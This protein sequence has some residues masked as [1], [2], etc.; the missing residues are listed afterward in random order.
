MKTKISVCLFDMGGV[1]ARH[2]DSQLEREIL[3]KLGI[4]GYKHFFDLDDRLEAVMLEHTKGNI[5]EEELWLRFSEIT[6]IAVD[7]KLGSLW[8]TY[9]HPQLDEAVLS[10]IRQLKD[11]GMRVVCATN[12]EIAHYSFHKKRG[13]YSLFDKVYASVD[14][15]EA[16]PDRK[17]FEKILESEN[18]APSQAFF[19]DDSQSNCDSAAS[20]GMK[21]FVF[22][23]V[24]ALREHLLHIEIL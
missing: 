22:T 13:D 10:L 17:F 14:L 12:T 8:G 2:S 19:I 15:H 1:V 6:D 16:K 9:F 24:D 4:K 3:A 11:K 7:R 21:V 20:L 5:T 18:L 23:S